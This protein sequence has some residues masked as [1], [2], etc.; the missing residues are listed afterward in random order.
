[1]CNLYSLT[2]G[3]SAIRDLF[4]VKRDRTGNLPPMPAIFAD[5]MAPIVRVGADDERELVLAR[6]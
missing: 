1:M 6:C 2:K 5:Q 4:R 3:P